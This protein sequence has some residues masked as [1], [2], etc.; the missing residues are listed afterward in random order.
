MEY[1]AASHRNPFD[2]DPP[3]DSFVPGYGVTSADF[4][5]VGDHP[6]VHGGRTTGVP[7]TDEPWSPQFFDALCRGGLVESFDSDTGAPAVEETFF[8][9]LHMC[10]PGAEQPTADD[11]AALEPFFDAELRA[12]TADVLLPVGPRATE[13]VLATFT[14]RS[15]EAIDMDALHASEIQ[16]TG[17]LVFPI[18]D[19]VEWTDD[20][21][22]RLVEGL[23]QLRSKDYRQLADLGRFSPGEEPYFVR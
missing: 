11:Y 10:D 16:G 19:P 5:V 1:I 23:T 3:C 8:S 12:I 7:F 4:H 6:G 18:A 22:D 15:P 20:E 13:H 14:N 21:A 17:W 2:F 9:Y